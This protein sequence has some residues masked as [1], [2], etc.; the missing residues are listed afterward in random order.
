MSVFFTVNKLSW[1]KSFLC[2]CVEHGTWMVVCRDNI[3]KTQKRILKKP[4]Y[5]VG[6][7]R[8][9]RAP[10]NAIWTEVRWTDEQTNHA[11]ID[12]MES[13]DQA[14]QWPICFKSLSFHTL[15]LDLSY[16][17]VIPCW[18]TAI[19][20][21]YKSTKPFQTTW[22]DPGGRRPQGLGR[23][24]RG[25]WACARRTCAWVSLWPGGRQLRFVKKKNAISDVTGWGGSGRGADHNEDNIHRAREKRKGP[26]LCSHSLPSRLSSTAWSHTC[27]WVA[28]NKPTPNT[29]TPNYKTPVDS[30]KFIKPLSTAVDWGNVFE[31]FAFVIEMLSIVHE[32]LLW[33][34]EK[35]VSWY[36][37]KISK[38]SS[39]ILSPKWEVIGLPVYP[40]SAVLALAYQTH[41]HLWKLTQN[42]VGS[43]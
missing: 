30:A 17:H 10:G 1:W 31:D 14:L 5:A 33:V 24:C 20:Q 3:W 38:G 41:M 15:H 27:T 2:E 29:W 12:W 39:S 22:Q 23:A 4:L 35:K 13:T 9:K 7:H 6:Q 28:T 16:K 26:T 25:R 21:T 18:K 32:H 37:C 40:A 19:F 42:K 34:S 8:D 11:L 43:N 36:F